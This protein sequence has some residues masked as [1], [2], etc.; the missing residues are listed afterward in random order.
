[1]R[2][3]VE[4]HGWLDLDVEALR[5]REQASSRPHLLVRFHRT[6]ACQLCHS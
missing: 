1:V 5:K 6:T 3:L 4:C 2:Q